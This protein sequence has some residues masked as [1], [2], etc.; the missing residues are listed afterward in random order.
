MVDVIA[1]VHLSMK[2]NMAMFGRLLREIVV[3][4]G[5]SISVKV[6]ADSVEIVGAALL[7]FVLSSRTPHP[8]IRLFDYLRS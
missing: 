7:P 2:A 8:I 1:T 3:L 6:K 5:T 4:R